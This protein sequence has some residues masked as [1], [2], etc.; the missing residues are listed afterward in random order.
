MKRT[1]DAAIKKYYKRIEDGTATA[2]EIEILPAMLDRCGGF[3]AESEIDPKQIERFDSMSEAGKR[4]DFP[5][6]GLVSAEEVCNF[7]GKGGIKK[8]TDSLL[9]LGRQGKL[10]MPVP[11]FHPHKWDSREI[12]TWFGSLKNGGVKHD[13]KA[14]KSV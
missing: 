9:K 11:G 12:R 1:I 7:L 6:E 3:L 8:K 4:G 2:A 13:E 10:P 5:D 14:R